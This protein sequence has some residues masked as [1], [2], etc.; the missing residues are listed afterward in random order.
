MKDQG[1]RQVACTGGGCTVDYTEFVKPDGL[2][3]IQGIA[4]MNL[5]KISNFRQFV[6]GT[7]QYLNIGD[8]PKYYWKV[9]MPSAAGALSDNAITEPMPWKALAMTYCYY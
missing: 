6:A 8:G 9:D 5:G 2:T 7:P 3:Y 4:D 1:A